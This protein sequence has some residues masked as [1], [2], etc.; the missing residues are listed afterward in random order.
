MLYSVP[1]GDK[2][3]SKACR[4][5]PGALPTNISSPANGAPL[6]F[7]LWGQ[8]PVWAVKGQMPMSAIGRHR[9]Q[10]GS[11]GFT[12]V[13]VVMVLALVGLASAAVAL[14]IRD[15]Q[16][17]LA[18]QLTRFESQ[19]RQA[20]ELSMVSGQ[21]VGL[22]FDPGGYRFWLRGLTGWASTDPLSEP[23][24]WP[25]GTDIVLW[26]N[27]QKVDLNKGPAQIAGSAQPNPE[28]WFQDFGLVTAFRLQLVGPKREIW[29][30]VG[31]DGSFARRLDGPPDPT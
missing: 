11:G 31:P 14:S 16:K 7:T 29:L 9:T 30:D 6:I 17:D 5:I 19:L 21:Q 1:K 13:E 20:Q 8:T 22:D 28:I 2:N 3:T 12:L 18:S 15:S 23:E 4:K 27:G 26:R 10:A 25:R 24:T